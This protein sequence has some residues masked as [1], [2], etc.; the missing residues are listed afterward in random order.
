AELDA[1]E[2]RLGLATTE[3]GATERQQMQGAASRDVAGIQGRFGLAQADLSN[4]GAL[5]RTQLEVDQRAQQV[6]D[7]LAQDQ[8][9]FEASPDNQRGAIIAQLAQLMLQAGDTR[10]AISALYG[11]QPA[12]P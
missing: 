7:M 8:A 12:A 3:R 11:T 2:G 6:A 9:Q 5:Q 10:G 1:L 4:T